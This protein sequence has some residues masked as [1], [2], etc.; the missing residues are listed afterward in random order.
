MKD[1]PIYDFLNS[2]LITGEIVRTPWIKAVNMLAITTHLLYFPIGWKPNDEV[3]LT[4][5]LVT[6]QLDKDAF[7]AEQKRMIESGLVD[8][9]EYLAEKGY[10]VA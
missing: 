2:D 9:K 8:F 10:V 5:V 7:I 3:Y 4:T 6:P 1:L